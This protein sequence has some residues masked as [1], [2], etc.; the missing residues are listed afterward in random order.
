MA[1]NK[2]HEEFHILNMNSGWETP[3]GYP[4]GRRSDLLKIL[5]TLRA[6][7]NVRGKQRGKQIRGLMP[8]GFRAGAS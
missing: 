4:K 7:E 6:R 8:R 3:P 5:P 1:V 2:N